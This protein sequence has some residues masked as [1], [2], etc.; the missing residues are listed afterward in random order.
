M[1][2]FC[3]Y[4]KENGEGVNL[5]SSCFVEWYILSFKDIGLLNLCTAS[6]LVKLTIKRAYF[7]IIKSNDDDS[8][9]FSELLFEK[10]SKLNI[11]GIF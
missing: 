11:S 5:L 3:I 6:S 1:K 8:K 9:L 7:F 4:G 2:P 10:Y